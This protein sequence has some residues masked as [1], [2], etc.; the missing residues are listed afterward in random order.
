[1]QGKLAALGLVTL[2]AV[3]CEASNGPTT[4]PDQDRF[5]SAMAIG[6]ACAAP[7]VGEVT[8]NS[9]E[10]DLTAIVEARFSL[11]STS[12][13]L[14]MAQALEPAQGCGCCQVT[15]PTL[16]FGMQ[17]EDLTLGEHSVGPMSDD[18]EVNLWLPD[19][20]PERATSGTLTFLGFDPET[21]SLC[22]ELQ[23]NFASYGSVAA[24]FRAR[25]ICP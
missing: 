2:L 9:P 5:P 23:A 20:E 12:G 19:A 22:G 15:R 8:I 7:D 13:Y 16:S 6:D 14:N 1:M 4:E 3:G 18:M 25:D 10:V 11:S 17:E 24:T 21:S